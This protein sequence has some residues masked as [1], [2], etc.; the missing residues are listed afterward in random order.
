MGIHK[1][2]HN[3]IRK[4]K[5]RLT[6]I[7]ISTCT[8]ENRETNITAHSYDPDTKDSERIRYCQYIIGI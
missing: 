7:D 4:K 3:I 5:R 1:T 6:I 8:N 2:M